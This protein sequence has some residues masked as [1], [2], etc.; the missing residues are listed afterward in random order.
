METTTSKQQK[1]IEFNA[2]VMAEVA[3]LRMHATQEEISNL[4]VETLNPGKESLCIY[5]QL[6]GDC[7]STRAQELMSISCTKTMEIKDEEVNNI[8]EALHTFSSLITNFNGA[9]T[10]KTWKKGGFFS[11]RRLYL[12]EKSKQ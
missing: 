4:N 2:A 8:T 6:T 11:I 3:S 7:S 1:V 12:L 10:G 9:Y 5:G